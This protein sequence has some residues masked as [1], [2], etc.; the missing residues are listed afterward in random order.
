MELSSQLAIIVAA[1]LFAR[2]SRILPSI[3]C[4]NIVWMIQYGKHGDDF[5]TGNGANELKVRTLDPSSSY[6][7]WTQ[8][9]E[10]L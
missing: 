2:P 9:V 4:S 10:F 3:P 6:L 7:R 5:N 8:S 1:V